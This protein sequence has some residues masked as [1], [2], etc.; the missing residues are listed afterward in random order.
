MTYWIVA[1]IALNLYVLIFTSAPGFVKLNAGMVTMIAFIAFIRIWQKKRSRTLER[2]V[3]EMQLLQ[4]E[5]E[6]LKNMM[7]QVD[8]SEEKFKEI[9]DRMDQSEN[10]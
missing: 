1:I 10:V 5:N 2:L 4:S 6:E 7:E 8:Q 9:V 3:D